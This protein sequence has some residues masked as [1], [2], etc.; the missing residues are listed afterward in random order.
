MVDQDEHI[1]YGGCGIPYYISGDLSDIKE[2][3]STSFHLLRTPEF[4]QG[5][6][7][8]HVRNRTR[9]LAI[10]RQARTVRVKDLASGSEEDLPYDYLVLA[11]GSRPRRLPLPGVY[12]PGVVN[13]SDLHTAMAIKEEISRGEVAQAVIIGAGPVG[14][15]MAEALRQLETAGICN[16]VNLQGGIA[17]LK[18][19]GLLEEGSE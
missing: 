16:A 14:P 13:V 1:A 3:M 19:S 8:V 5:A 6:K 9:A 12:L 15:E 18:K 17:A 2:L 10:D 11:T 7:G 4:F